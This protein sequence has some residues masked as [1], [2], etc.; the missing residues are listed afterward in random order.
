M[1][2]GSDTFH[3]STTESPAT[4]EIDAKEGEVYFFRQDARIG[5]SSGRVTMKQADNK[6]GMSE[7]ENCK[8]L[9]SSYIPE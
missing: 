9:I 1:K 4:V 5:L 7:V 8:L 6:Q 3:S 2:P